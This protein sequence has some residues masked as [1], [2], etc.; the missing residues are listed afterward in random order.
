MSV[1]MV[2]VRDVAQA[3]VN[4]LLREDATNGKR[5][6]VNAATMW[7]G[8]IVAILKAEFGQLGYKTPCFNVG[9]V[10]FKIAS[11]FDPQA[12]QLSDWVDRLITF[13]NY[14]SQKE[15]GLT[16]RHPNTTLI[17]MGY[18]MIELGYIPKTKKH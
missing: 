2:D 13:D 1:A 8:D 14:A 9:S 16:Y 11:W 17:E 6:L 3:H 7:F 4:A 5:Y 12:R 10:L 15:L 18:N